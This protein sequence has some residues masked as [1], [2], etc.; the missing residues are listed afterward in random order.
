M[1]D[2]VSPVSAAGA[3]RRA[4]RRSTDPAVLREDAD[5]PVLSGTNLPVPVP[6]LRQEEPPAAAFE[7][8][9]LGQ[10]GQKRG[11]RGG[12][13]VLNAARNAYLDAEWSGPADRRP[14]KG[15]LTKTEI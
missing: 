1:G 5:A 3:E 7:A 15:V 14:P 8:Q 13:P 10:E 4:G 9:L 6:P 12:E 2:T 11:L